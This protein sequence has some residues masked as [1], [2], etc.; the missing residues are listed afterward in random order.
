MS[1]DTDTAGFDVGLGEHVRLTGQLVQDA[2]SG[3]TP[4]ERRPRTNGL[5]KPL[6]VITTKRTTNCS[7]LQSTTQTT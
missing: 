7:R 6:A 4:P 5:F 2:I 1:I 3:A